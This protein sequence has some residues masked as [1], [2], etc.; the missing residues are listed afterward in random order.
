[1]NCINIDISRHH[2]PLSVIRH[3]HPSAY[4]ARHAFP[5]MSVEQEE[6][7]RM[8]AD[9][10]ILPIHIERSC[11]V[12]IGVILRVTPQEVWLTEDNGWSDDFEVTSNTSW[13]I[14]KE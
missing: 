1:M 9:R 14:Y 12:S 6:K 8:S 4:A 3:A 10:Q 13:T 2:T 7:P 5:S 11:N